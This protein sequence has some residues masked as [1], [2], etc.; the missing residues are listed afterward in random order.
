MD[1]NQVITL[2]LGTPSGIPH[3]LLFGLSPDAGIAATAD[4]IVSV[5]ADVG[6]ISI[7]P[8]VGFI[9]VRPDAGAIEP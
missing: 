8:A 9:S 6:V 3:F 1:V 7:R 4:Y 5:R 2:G